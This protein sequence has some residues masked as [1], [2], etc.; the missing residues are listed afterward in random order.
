VPLFGALFLAKRAT[1]KKN[2][3]IYTRHGYKTL[4]MEIK[5]EKKE[6]KDLHSWVLKHPMTWENAPAT[7]K[8][9][10][11][12]EII[13]D[14]KIDMFF[15]R[16]GELAVQKAFGGSFIKEGNG[17]YGGDWLS[18]KNKIWEIKTQNILNR[19]Y[20][21]LSIDL[22]WKQLKRYK[23]N[24]I[25]GIILC[26]AEFSLDTFIVNPIINIVAYTFIRHFE[27]SP[28]KKKYEGQHSIDFSI[29]ENQWNFYKL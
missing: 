9:L 11:K 15:G 27:Y 4:I 17:E 1:L 16:C 12:E 24:N 10:S 21:T 22:T 29:Y 14:K 23:A 28:A 3:Y 19:I 8:H 6:I 18:P 5:L 26:T 13:L 2:A 25:K 7:K 20:P